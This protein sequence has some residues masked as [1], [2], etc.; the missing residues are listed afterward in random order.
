[1]LRVVTVYPEL[2]STYGDGGNALVLASRARRRGL[3]VE[4]VAV[5]LGSPLAGGDLYL[6]GGGEDGP[7]R[8]AADALRADGTLSE[9]V[10]G[11]AVVFAVCA[12]LQILGESFAV[13]G[14]ALHQGTG[15]V[16]VTTRR[17]DQRR[18]GH[19]LGDVNGR[20]MVGFENHGGV[21]ALN[22]CAP[23]GSVV[24][25]FGN[26]G[27]TDGVRVGRVIATYAHGPALALNPWLADELVSLATGR[28]LEPIS[29]IADQLHH[30]R[31]A[32]VRRVSPTSRGSS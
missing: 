32:W 19:L 2:L 25:G 31:C 3:D 12:G 5:R 18:V 9:R 26:D 8:Q 7:Q 30:E 23:L 13:D 22:G 20:P 16:P 27:V 28:T 21:T 17:S 1:M 15:L 11:G 10:D 6:L 29:T 4:T 24:R 14:D